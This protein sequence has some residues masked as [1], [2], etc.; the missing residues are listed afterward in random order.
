MYFKTSLNICFTI[1]GFIYIPQFTSAQ[2][3]CLNPNQRSGNC[4]S[5]YDCPSLLSVAARKPL[6]DID[7]WFLRSSQCRGGLG[8]GP[9]VCCT[10]DTDYVRQPTVLFP[11]ENVN[12]S[13]RGE[14][15]ELSACGGV[16]LQNKIFGG[17]DTD[18]SEFPWLAMLEYEKNGQRSTNCGGSLINRRYVITAAHCV[19]GRIQQDVGTLVGVIL[20]EHDTTKIID[21]VNGTCAGPALRYG[22]EEAIPHE[23]YNDR[24]VHR[25]NDIALVRLDRN[26]IYS[27]QIKPI[28]LPFTLP[29]EQLPSGTMLTVVGWGR[30]QDTQRSTIK[31][32]VQVP[33]IDQ[34]EC[35]EK[36]RRG[37]IQIIDKQVCAGGNYEKDSCHGDS[38]GPL[39]SFRQGVWVL[40]GIISYGY[41]CGHKGWPAVHSRVPSYENWIRGV[42]RA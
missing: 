29:N 38:G 13:Q 31:Q 22:V 33:L 9:H 14:L 2:S 35:R 30:T 39:M 17:D 34:D 5:I 3:Q 1:L 19:T 7:R 41:E 40:E 37:N 12:Q 21:C 16:K 20:G 6:Q 4:I 24:Q 18:L 11:A 23:S 8:N 15:P 25:H 42:I 27:D 26:V 28:C 10:D 36:F 32:K